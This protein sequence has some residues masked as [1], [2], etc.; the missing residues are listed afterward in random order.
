MKF[1]FVLIISLKLLQASFYVEV[2]Q[3]RFIDLRSMGYEKK[4]ILEGSHPSYDFIIPI[5]RGQK[6][7]DVTFFMQL[8]QVLNPKSTITVLVD[9]VPLFTNYIKEIGYEPKISFS[10]ELNSR[11]KSVKITI[12]LNMF[13]TGDFCIDNNSENL[14]ST[15]ELSSGFKVDVPQNIKHISSFFKDYTKDINIIDNSAS[16]DVISLVYFLNKLNTTN[17]LETKYSFTEDM[18]SKNVV[19]MGNS[20]EIKL[21]NNTLYLSSKSLKSLNSQWSA[22]FATSYLKNTKIVKPK[23]KKRGFKRLSLKDF[24]LKSITQKGLG[25]LYFNI[26][27]NTR[28]FGGVAKNLIF[29]LHFNHTPV[30]GKERGYLNIFFN[31]QLMQ[32]FVLDDES[33][34]K[35]YPIKIP[36]SFINTGFNKLVVSTSFYLNNEKCIGSIPKL[37]ATM[38]NSSYFSWDKINTEVDSVSSFL[39]NLQGDVLMIVESELKQSAMKFAEKLGKNNKSINN[40]DIKSSLDNLTKKQNSYN[41]IIIFANQ[42]NFTKQRWDLPLIVNS[43]DFSIYNA[44]DKSLVFSSQ[45][46]DDFSFI[47][48]GSFMDTPLFAVSYFNTEQAMEFFDS[49]NMAQLKEIDSNLAF[50]TKDE[51]VAYHTDRNLRDSNESLDILAEYWENYKFPI[52]LFIAFIALSLIF[53]SYRKLTKEME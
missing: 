48:T 15:I 24:K 16:I 52:L 49:T 17:Q 38:F 1:L 33:K 22:L 44:I 37:K 8:S 14:W 6:L 40:L 2:G 18:K 7:I 45:N 46:W 29:N 5:L 20:D 32:S 53:I 34:I 31:D 50:I 4:I 3:D 10:R 39:K 19:I 12:R 13:I 25:D 42:N 30:L 43:N 26:P 21:K 11:K 41:S 47:Q 23:E 51:I 35:N 27:F 28:D 36:K 9:D